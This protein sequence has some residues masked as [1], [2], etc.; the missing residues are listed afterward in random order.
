MALLCDTMLYP[1]WVTQGMNTVST[2]NNG[3][4]RKEERRLIVVENDEA[5]ASRT[6]KQQLELLDSRLGEGVGA[7]K[8]RSRLKQA[9][10]TVGR[11]KKSGGKSRQ[12]ES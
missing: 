9:M 11:G 12:T 8:E 2:I 3:R 6:P 4:R 5:R 10:T 7:S 1:T